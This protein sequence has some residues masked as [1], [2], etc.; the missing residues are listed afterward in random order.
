MNKALRWLL[1]LERMIIS[2]D[3]ENSKNNN[4][5]NSGD[6]INNMVMQRK[7]KQALEKLNRPTYA[8]TE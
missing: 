1:E 3:N 7:G 2:L 8:K 6:N 5:Y 4:N